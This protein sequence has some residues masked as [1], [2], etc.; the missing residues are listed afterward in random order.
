MRSTIRGG[1]APQS[2]RSMMLMDWTQ[3]TADMIEQI[4]KLHNSLLK[5]TQIRTYTCN[6]VSQNIEAPFVH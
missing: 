3:T 4:D 5:I 1:R 6:R 2:I